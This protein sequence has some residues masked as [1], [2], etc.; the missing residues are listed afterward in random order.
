MMKLFFLGNEDTFQ[1]DGSKNPVN[2]SVKNSFML[3]LSNYCLLLLPF[4]MMMMTM[5]PATKRNLKRVKNAR[6]EERKNLLRK[7]KRRS[8]RRMIRKRKNNSKILMIT[9]VKKA[10]AVRKKTARN[11]LQRDI[12]QLKK[13]HRQMRHHQSKKFANNST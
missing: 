8:E 5:S 12:N 11:V 4:R 9:A 3:E 2:V 6:R 1:D 13:N 7:T 10:V